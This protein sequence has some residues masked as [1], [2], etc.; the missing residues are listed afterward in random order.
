MLT[1]NVYDS[2]IRIL[3]E[4]LQAA[5]GCTEPIAIAYCAAKLRAVLKN[6]PERVVAEVSG[7]ILK[8]VKSVIVPNTGG[9]RGIPAAVA[10]GIVAGD[11][12]R[13]LQV[14]SEIPEEKKPEIAVYEQNTPIEVRCSDTPR[15]LDI[16]LTGW[17]GTDQAVVHIA[18]NHSNIVYIEYNGC[19]LAEKPL[20]DSPEDSLEDKS[21]LNVKD[22]L[23]FAAT[24]D[25][26]RVSVLLERQIAFN[27]A[28][29]GEGLKGDWGAGIGRILLE[30]RGTD[31]QNEAKAY[32]AAGSDARMSGCEMPVVIVSGSGNQGITASLPVIRYSLHLK[33]GKEKLYRALL[34][35]NL[36]TIHQKTGIGRLSAYCGAVSAGVGS[37]A[38]I[39]YLKGGDYKAIAHTVVNAVAILSGTI[40]D[41]AKPSCAAKIASAVDAGILGYQ[42]YCHHKQF[43]DGDGIVKKG[44]E[45]TI[46]NV[47]TLAREG[48]KQTDR[49]ILDIMTGG[50]S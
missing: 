46:A 24:V 34:I 43:L 2:Y 3:E 25:L 49:T 44:V 12:D 40:C 33:A 14:I 45:N 7:N 23:E 41:G 9:R 37:G 20:Q 16:R 1:A 26:D 13:I 38:A 42:M 4:E 10:A 27:S 5:T 29:A 47:G 17:F 36:I 39:A 31:I 35:S 11:A 50:A 21:L 30:E 19:V 15:L 8:N 48:M 32:A 22:I 28:I 6:A 18:N